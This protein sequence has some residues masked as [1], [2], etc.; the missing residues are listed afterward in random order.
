M[1]KDVLQYLLSSGNITKH[2]KFICTACNDK[3]NSILSKYVDAIPEMNLATAA[4]PTEMIETA[5][6]GSALTEELDGD[7]IISIEVQVDNIIKSLK[8]ESNEHIQIVPHHK[9]QELLQLLGKHYLKGE[10]YLEGITI[11][12]SYKNPAY[13]QSFN[14]SEYIKKRALAWYHF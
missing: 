4:I 13:L 12:D 7:E 11:K 8:T 3:V 1:K 9:I 10:V 2:T 14:P 6:K 5:E